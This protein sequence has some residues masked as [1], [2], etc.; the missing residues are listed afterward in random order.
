M[1]VFCRGIRGAISVEEETP[2]AL[3]RAARTLVEAIMTQN[4]VAW[5]DVVSVIFTATPDLNEA[6]PAQV[7]PRIGGTDIPTL[8]GQEMD[9][10]GAL[11]RC[12]RVLVLVNTEKS[13][14][15]LR[16]VYLGAARALRPDLAE[17]A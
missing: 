15:E 6:Y 3:E 4:E 7:L 12:L 9:V 2:E 13:A 16:H 1:P 8:C 17:E 11:E 5:E 14:R 10:P